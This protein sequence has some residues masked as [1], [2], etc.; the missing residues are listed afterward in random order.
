MDITVLMTLVPSA[1][2]NRDM[3][4]Y[5][6]VDIIRETSLACEKPALAET[7]YQSQRPG[8]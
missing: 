5:G 4:D 2:A 8:P 1:G 7:E 3:V 6:S